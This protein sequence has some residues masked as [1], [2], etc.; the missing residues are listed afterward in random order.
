M[1]AKATVRSFGFSLLEV[2]LVTA[3]I[4]VIAT[5]AAPRFG[6]ARG[7]YQVDLAARR[8]VADLGL[9]QSHAKSQSAACTVSFSAATETYQ[10]ADVSALD[11]DATDY[12]VDLTVQPYG[13]DLASANF[14]GDS[15]VVFDGWGLPDSAGTVVVTVQSEQRT[16]V[17]DAETGKA[18]VQ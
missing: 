7:R 18:A 16:I 14:G 15:D 12:T 10:L 13:A 5:I 2:V 4:A 17:L 9:A 11:G 1:D 3:I 8:I 6:M